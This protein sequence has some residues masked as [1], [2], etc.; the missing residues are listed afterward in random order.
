MKHRRVLFTTI[1]VGLAL[2]V[3]SPA[4][5]GKKRVAVLEI[6]GARDDRLRNDVAKLLKKQARPLPAKDFERAQRKLKIKRLT[7]RN[8]RKVAQRIEADGVIEGI[9]VA[10]GSG[11]V[12]RLRLREGAT[13]RTVRKFTVFLKSPRMSRSIAKQLQKK[14]VAAV[15]NLEPVLDDPPEPRE[16]IEDE[17]FDDVEEGAEFEDE[18]PV[19]QLRKRSKRSKRSKRAKRSRARDFIDDSDMEA[20]PVDNDDDAE[21]EEMIDED[22]DWDDDEEIEDEDGDTRD[23]DRDDDS[24][25][26]RRADPTG[27][28]AVISI[29]AGATVIGRSLKFA[30][31]P[32]LMTPPSEYNG[33]YAPGATLQGEFFPLATGD[34]SDSPT[35]KLGFAVDI[36]RSVGLS[37]QVQG[38]DAMAAPVKLPTQRQKY[39]VHAL[40][41]HNFGTKST[42]PSATVSVGYNKLAFEVD[43]SNAPE[44][45][46]I[47]VPNVAYSYVDPG[48]KLR[49]PA[50]EKLALLA[51]GKFMAV[52]DAGE[53]VT[54][55]QYGKS[56]VVGF[57]G[58]VGIEVKAAARWIVRAGAHLTLVGYTF[59]QGAGE[60]SSNRDGD[61]ATLD[62]GGASDRYLGG[63]LTA[64]YLY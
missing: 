22:D 19:R 3:G 1:A 4:F 16:R 64:G 14:L 31:R 62:V 18:E 34:K 54:A 48:L 63:Y 6:E 29:S 7:A 58:D 36:E 52:L 17:E 49:F 25:D 60:L 43:L 26:E 41:R 35:T 15:G 8:V 24:G 47:D 59:Q 13:G 40:Y 5:A 12:L 32:D 57:D 46:I 11:Y 53:M 9:L 28:T 20:L 61:L 27:R 2:L 44:G 51:E 30:A 39:G 55:E 21:E 56:T 10:E 37:S 45:V 23:S 33:A 50:G 42:H 38:P